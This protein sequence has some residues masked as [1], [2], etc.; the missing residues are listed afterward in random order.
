MGGAS[1]LTNKILTGYSAWLYTSY[2][3]L[4][5]YSLDTSLW[6][7]TDYDKLQFGIWAGM[8]DATITSN[9][10]AAVGAS[11]AEQQWGQ[12]TGNP[13]AAYTDAQL[14]AIGIGTVDFENSTWAGYS[15]GDSSDGKYANTGNILVLNMWGQ[16]PYNNPTN[17]GNAQDQLGYDPSQGQPPIPEP[18]SFIVWGL[19]GLCGFVGT[20]G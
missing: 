10:K 7:K 18:I 4:D 11:N 15:S 6:T 16:V 17:P 8:I 1:I 19:M 20:D 3:G 9:L 2:L 5:G 14:D 13:V 12:T